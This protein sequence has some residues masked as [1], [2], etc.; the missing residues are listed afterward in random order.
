MRRLRKWAALPLAALLV[1]AVAG[2]GRTQDD[3][4]GPA[5]ARAA[6]ARLYATL[7]QVIDR[8]VDLYNNGDYAGCYRLY[9][10]ALMVAGPQLAHRPELQK[11]VTDGR[12]KADSTP[13]VWQRAWVLRGVLDKIRADVNPN[14]PARKAPE[15]TRPPEGTRPPPDRRP[16]PSPTP[17]PPPV[18]TNPPPAGTTLW[19]RLGG[20]KGVRQVVDEIVNAV[21]TDPKVDF[22]RGGKYKL[23]KAGVQRLENLLVEQVSS[24]TG[25]PLRYEG[26]DM[27]EAHKGMGITNAEFDAFMSHV[28]D[29]LEK[30]KV[31]AADVTTIMHALDGY[32]KDMVETP[33]L[34]KPGGKGTGGK[35]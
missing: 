30:H 25:G 11:V 1:G 22:S 24:L 27:K 32:R 33:A 3:K 13:V 5:D 4:P 6:D 14:P 20:E 29:V 9:E 31:A 19:Q 2:P 23:D 10:G 12:T 17:S 26:L 34:R 18:D 35:G 28:R 16:P 15:P 21:A 8:G 7:A